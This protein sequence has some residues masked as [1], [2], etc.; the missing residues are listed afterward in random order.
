MSRRNV[1]YLIML[2]GI[3]SW[4]GC[5][6]A[7]YVQVDQNAGVVSIPANTNTWPNYYRDHAEALMRQKC[8][9]GYEVVYEEEAVVNQVAHTHTDTQTQA[10]PVLGLG[11]VQTDG[12]KDSKSGSFA[13]LAVPLGSGHETSQQTTN[14]DNVA[15]WRIH[16]RAKQPTQPGQPAPAGP[17]AQPYPTAPPGPSAIQHS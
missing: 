4:I 8:P 7:R 16:Y 3:T 11:G 10:P 2:L 17:V 6:N 13:G 1:P 14:Y 9:Q 12:K 15:E 5:A